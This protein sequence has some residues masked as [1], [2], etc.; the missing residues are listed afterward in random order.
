MHGSSVLVTNCVILL[1]WTTT[2]FCLFFPASR[3]IH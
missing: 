1:M 3:N 2:D